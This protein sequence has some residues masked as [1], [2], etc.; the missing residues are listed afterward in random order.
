MKDKG[1]VSND[2]D[3]I[4]YYHQMLLEKRGY[5]VF[6]NNRLIHPKLIFSDTEPDVS[7]ESEEEINENTVYNE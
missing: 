2:N 4:V 3:D 7:D 1:I 6:S 5:K